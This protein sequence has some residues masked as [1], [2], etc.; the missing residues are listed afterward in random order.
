MDVASV[1]RAAE[2]VHLSPAAVSLQLRSLA[3]ELETE[4]FVRDK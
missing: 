4:L 3:D 1:T 2:H